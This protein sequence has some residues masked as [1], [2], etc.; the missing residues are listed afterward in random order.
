M[1]S[2]MGCSFWNG[3]HL[4]AIEFYICLLQE[5]Q[6]E[7]VF[8]RAQFTE[9][10]ESLSKE[11]I[12]LEKK[13]ATLEAREKQILESHKEMVLKY[14]AELKKQEEK[15]GCARRLFWFLFNILAKGRDFFCQVFCTWG[16]DTV[17]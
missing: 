6:Q 17:K 11:K 8:L 9:K 5:L 10:T 15:V 16:M 7:N 14:T 1:A 13:L 2:S 12:E 4:R 3:G